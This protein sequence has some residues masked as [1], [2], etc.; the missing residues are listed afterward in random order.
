[1]SKTDKRILKEKRSSE[2]KGDCYGMSMTSLLASQGLLNPADYMDG[3]DTLRSITDRPKNNDKVESIINYYQLLQYTTPHKQARAHQQELTDK[4]KLELMVSYL[5][6]DTEVLFVFFKDNAK[7]NTVGHAVVAYDID[8]LDTPELKMNQFYCDGVIKLYD[9]TKT[10]AIDLFFNSKTGSWCIPSR[11]ERTGKENLRIGYVDNNLNTLNALGCLNGTAGQTNEE[12]LPILYSGDLDCIYM[13]YDP[14]DDSADGSIYS[15]VEEVYVSSNISG[16]SNTME[17]TFM[18]GNKSYTM[19][20]EDTQTVDMDMSYQDSLLHIAADAAEFINFD[21]AGSI[22]FTGGKSD[23]ELGLT[24]NDGFYVTDWY[25]LDVAGRSTDH[26]TLTQVD[27]GY[28][29]S[30]GSLQNILVNAGCDEREATLFFSTQYKEV[31]IYEIDRNTIGVAVDTDG[32]GTYE[33]TI[34]RSGLAHSG[35]LNMDGSVTIV[36]VVFANKVLMGAEE[37]VH[38]GQYKAADCDGSG[39]LDPGDSLIILK[40]LV[41]LLDPLGLPIEF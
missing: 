6:A 21:P 13:F 36:D 32:N 33:T 14:N 12:Y 19:R 10:T 34:A 11:F 24:F 37:I 15:G 20:V 23:Y 29:L 5:E 30:A 4:E 27:N 16:E 2:W 38:E 9:N 25:Q 8:Y 31:L 7:G 39:I 40:S 1:M 41:S 35:D 26:A 22:G 17:F 28:L 3:A 18:G